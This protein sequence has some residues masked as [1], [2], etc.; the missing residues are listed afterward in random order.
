MLLITSLGYAEEKIDSTKL[1]GN[2]KEYDGKIIIYEGEVIGDI[3]LRGKYAW[4]NVNDG[5]GTIG[6]WVDRDLAK[7][8]SFTGNYRYN[9]D[10][11]E[12]KGIFNRACLQHGGDLDI[13]AKTIRI[14]RKGSLRED[15][16]PAFKINLG[17]SLIIAYLLLTGSYLLKE[18]I[19]KKKSA[20]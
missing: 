13:H 5:K 1:I 6:V 9:G 12:I 7:E 20:G 17:V 11:I 3:M 8:V 19:W 16:I 4:I 18:L 14:I 2:A 10:W 15:K